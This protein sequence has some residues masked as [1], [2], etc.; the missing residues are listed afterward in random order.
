M[1]I[2]IVYPSGIDREK[3]KR[4]NNKEKCEDKLILI[5]LTSNHNTYAKI[6]NE[7]I[8]NIFRTQCNWVIGPVRMIFSFSSVSVFSDTG[9]HDTINRT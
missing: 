5:T 7:L 6:Q 9:S 3:F 8:I 4:N 1:N 2:V